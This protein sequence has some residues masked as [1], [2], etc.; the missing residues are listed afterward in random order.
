MTNEVVNSEQ[1]EILGILITKNEVSNMNMEY[2]HVANFAI[3]T[4]LKTIRLN[5]PAQIEAVNKLVDRTPNWMELEPEEQSNKIKTVLTIETVI[6]YL[7]LENYI[8][9]GIDMIEVGIDPEGTIIVSAFYI[10]KDEVT[11]KVFKDQYTEEQI[12]QMEKQL[13]VLDGSINIYE[14]AK[15]RVEKMKKN[16]VVPFQNR[17][18]RRLAKNA[19]KVR[20]PHK[21][22]KKK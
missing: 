2:I 8:R 11:D 20:L 1:K 18:A 3:E 16:N 5:E 19:K 21:W 22:A 6:E 4:I 13:N 9:E 17:A 14:E 10:Q 15:K 7:R 12:N